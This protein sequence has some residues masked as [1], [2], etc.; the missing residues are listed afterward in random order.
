MTERE[1]YHHVVASILKIGQ[2]KEGEGGLPHERTSRVKKTCQIEPRDRHRSI[3]ACTDCK[4]E[5][6]LV[7][8]IDLR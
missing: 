7:F 2:W 3:K 5:S 1:K 4:Q 8:S 6:H